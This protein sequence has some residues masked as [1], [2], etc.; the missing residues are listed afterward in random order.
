MYQANHHLAS[1]GVPE[2]DHSIAVDLARSDELVDDG[3][4]N[5]TSSCHLAATESR[6]RG[7]HR[8]SSP[9]AVEIDDDRIA[10]SH[11]SIERTADGL[12]EPG[13]GLVGAVEGEN[14]GGPSRMLLGSTTRAF[15]G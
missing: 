9:I 8:S 11:K 3:A 1:G 2:T 12:V 10:A 6:S 7:G 14:H 15:R 13:R 5:E 4:G